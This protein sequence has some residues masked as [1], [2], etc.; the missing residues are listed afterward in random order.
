MP[1]PSP[2]HPERKDQPQYTLKRVRPAQQVLPLA[3]LRS[4]GWNRAV[5]GGVGVPG[6]AFVHA[7]NFFPFRFLINASSVVPM[8]R[9]SQNMR[10]PT[11]RYC[12]GGPAHAT[13]IYATI[14]ATKKTTE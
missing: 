8:L 4:I 7:P 6:S 1:H 11:S 13:M 3:F 12:Q 9:K 10:Q 5:R 14:Y 2:C